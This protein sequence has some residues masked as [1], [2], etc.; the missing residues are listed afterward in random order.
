MNM[1]YIEYR[2][3]LHDDQNEV[4]FCNRMN[5]MHRRDCIIDND[6]QDVL[7]RQNILSFQVEIPDSEFETLVNRTLSKFAIRPGPV[8]GGRSGNRCRLVY[9]KPFLMRNLSQGKNRFLERQVRSLLC[10]KD[11]CV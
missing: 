6:M 10:P 7:R 1:F 11:V 2:V 5:R 4:P 9:R 8:S 3:V